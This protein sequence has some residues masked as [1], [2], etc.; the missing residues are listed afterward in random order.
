MKCANRIEE[1]KEG[2]RFYKKTSVVPYKTLISII[3]DGA[4]DDVAHKVGPTK[5]TCT[6]AIG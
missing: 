3:W 5:R 1:K 6:I 2:K 4:H